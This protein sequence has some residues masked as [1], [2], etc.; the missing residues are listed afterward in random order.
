KNSQ[1]AET[2]VAD[3]RIGHQF[4]HVFLHQRDERAVD[5]A[6][7]GQTDHP[8]AHGGMFH[9]VGEEWEREANEAISSHLQQDAGQN[10]RAGGWGFDVG[11]G[12]PGMEREHGNFDRKC[13]EEREEQQDGEGRAVG[14]IVE[15]V[16][17]GLIQSLNAEGIRAGQMVVVVVKEQH[18]QQHQHGPEQGVQ[19]ELDSRIEFA[20]AAPD[21]DEQIHRNQH[22]FPE[23]EEEEEVERHEDAQHAGLQHQKPDVIF[24]D[25][26][27]D[28]GPG[29][30]NRNPAE[31]RGQHDQQEG[32]AVD[33]EDVTGTD[34]GNPIVGRALHELEAGLE[35]LRPEPRHERKRDEEAGESEDVGDPANGIL[36]VLGDEQKQDRAHQ[37]REQDDGENVALHKCSSQN[38]K[39]TR[40]STSPYKSVVGSGASSRFGLARGCRSAIG[41][42]ENKNLQNYIK[43]SER[44]RGSGSRPEP[45]GP[46]QFHAQQ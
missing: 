44:N 6:N 37:R 45:F 20:R 16:W 30:E 46:S 43:D 4:L 35:A 3:G 38:P 23:N 31:Q 28:G 18:G 34:R 32:N 21:A 7:D 14:G 19:E 26:V 33:A 12:Q 42:A 10:H 36:V 17:R 2:E 13:E 9:H 22:G 24:L 25:P 40:L 41:V 27:L 8:G 11:V 39:E 5:D 15:N 29:G 1:G